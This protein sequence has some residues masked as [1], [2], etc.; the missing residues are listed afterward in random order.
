MDFGEAPILPRQIEVLTAMKILGVDITKIYGLQYGGKNKYTLYPCGNTPLL[1]QSEMLIC[2]HR[3]TITETA[4]IIREIEQR[5]MDVFISGLPLEIDTAVVLEK[6]IHTHKP[7]IRMDKKAQCDGHDNV[8]T[9]ER[10]L[11][12]PNAQLKSILGALYVLGFLVKTWYKGYKK[13]GHVRDVKA[14]D[15]GLRTAN[16]STDLEE[17]LTQQKQP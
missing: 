10:I 17:T 2:G 5:N 7:H 9:G 16:K 8:H 13:I 1:S 14:L 4:P 12:I 3:V 6:L 11:K 15:M